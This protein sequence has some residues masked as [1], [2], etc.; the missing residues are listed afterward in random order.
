M[1][2]TFCKQID[3]NFDVVLDNISVVLDNPSVVLDKERPVFTPGFLKKKK[4][5]ASCALEV[6][7]RPATTSLHSAS[8]PRKDKQP[9]TWRY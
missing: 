8:W 6:A 5:P 4:I 3:K 1:S 7:V 2:K 9:R